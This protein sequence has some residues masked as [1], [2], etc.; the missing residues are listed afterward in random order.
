MVPLVLFKDTPVD[1]LKPNVLV[2]RIQPNEGIAISFNAKVPGTAMRIGGVDMDFCNVDYFDSRPTT[3][4]ET[5]LYDCMRGDAGLF[6]RG[7][8][9]EAAWSVVDPVL[10]VWSALPPRDFPNYAAGSWG[11]KAA[12]ELLRRDGRRWRRL[13]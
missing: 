13:G 7:D 2:L 8:N 12:G 1:A 4:Y 11:P 3:G 5:L 9:A 6:Q 10:D